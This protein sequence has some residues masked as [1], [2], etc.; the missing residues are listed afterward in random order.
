MVWPTGSKKVDHIYRGHLNARNRVVAR[1]QGRIVVY[2]DDLVY[3]VRDESSDEMMDSLDDLKD[4]SDD[5]A[6]F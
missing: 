3:G 6:N 2:N 1:G 5:D 4:Y